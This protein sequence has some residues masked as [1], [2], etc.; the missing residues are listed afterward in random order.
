VDFTTVKSQGRLFF[1]EFFKQTF[2]SSHLA[3]PS[4]NPEKAAMPAFDRMAIEE[5][6]IK[7]VKLPAVATGIVFF[8]SKHVAPHTEEGKGENFASRA[9][10]VAMDTLR[11]GL[12][13]GSFL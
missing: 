9:C 3:N 12:D 11:T 4:A 13:V 1:T 5:V 7:A 8:L 2:F 6:F 10:E